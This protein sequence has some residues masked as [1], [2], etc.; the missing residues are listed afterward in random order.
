MSRTHMSIEY[1]HLHHRVNL[2]WVNRERVRDPWA[3]GNIVEWVH[4][5]MG[6]NHPPFRLALPHQRE[7]LNLA[8]PLPGSICSLRPWDRTTPLN[9]QSNQSINWFIGL[10]I[11]MGLPSWLAGKEEAS[12]Q[13]RGIISI[14][15][16]AWTPLVRVCQAHAHQAQF[17]HLPSKEAK[18]NYTALDINYNR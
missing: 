16:R 7:W 4:L 13:R 14:P 17:R 3:V 10:S 9:W 2:F 15:R 12:G 6:L 18:Y 8:P 1:S 11:L 5:T